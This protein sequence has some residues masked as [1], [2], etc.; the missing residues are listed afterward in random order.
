VAG[1]SIEEVG[2]INRN[3]YH[4]AKEFLAYLRDVTQIDGSSQGRY[5]SYLKWLLVWAD[6]FSFGKVIDRRPT[7]AAYLSS[8]GSNVE[9]ELAPVTVKKI[10][11]TAKRF[12][13]WAKTKYPS[14]FREIAVDW[15]EA[16]R[17]P[18]TAE[19]SHEHRFIR[20]EEVR[21][22]AQVEVEPADV[23]SRRDRAASVMLF[24]SGMR[25]SA[26][27]SLTLECVDL[28]SRTIKQW[29]SLGVKTKNGKS[30]TTY[31][32]EIPDLLD[33]VAEWDSFV[34]SSLPLS[35]SW[36]TPIVS[37]W[38]EQRLSPEAPGANRGI[39][40]GKRL[41]KLF[42]SA[43]L[44]Y[45]SPHQ[46]R[47]GDAVFALQHAD[48]MADYK[49]VSMNLM[50]SDIRVTDGIYALLARDEVKHRIADLTRGSGL[51]KA[52]DLAVVPVLNRLSDQ[53]LLSTLAERLRCQP[54]A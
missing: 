12:F 10:F 11:Q 28:A 51:G 20:L 33:V 3:N 53:E 43:G 30:A 26:F 41:R 54:V 8:A 46:F 23:A 2:L 21:A 50:H 22:I 42:S 27:G 6:G 44:P 17:L 9:R 52:V 19:T 15:I 29:P 34:R 49:A 25:A 45:R 4:L 38:G 36:Y 37:E 5:W 16:L 48:T 7:F 14:D 40:L 13:T 35:A 24:L 18:R 47:H 31:L 39:A 1:P 32:L